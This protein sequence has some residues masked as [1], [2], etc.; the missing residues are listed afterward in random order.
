MNKEMDWRGA[1]SLINWIGVSIVCIAILLGYSSWRSDVQLTAYAQNIIREK[2]EGNRL[3][4]KGMLP[5]QVYDKTVVF[6]IRY[7][8][9]DEKIML[10]LA[11]QINEMFMDTDI[12]VYFVNDAIR[13]HK[14]IMALIERSEAD[15]FI[16]LSVGADKKNSET[17][18]T[19]CF[20]NDVFFIPEYG[21]VQ[22][23][24]ALLHR[25]VEG[26]SGKALGIFPSEQK[27]ILREI[28]IPA[29]EMVV[30]YQT[31]EAEG[32]LLLKEGY[33]EQIAKGIKNAVEAYYAGE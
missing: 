20:Y 19:K 16:A 27:S 1:F 13:E 22:L 5:E 28:T 29:T 24:D 30:G 14:D 23:A 17:F 15:L 18:G 10:S 3:M 9:A 2:S 7:T 32:S 33:R 12:M 4:W 26:I 21:N 31:N 11:E 6:D 8:D 25:V